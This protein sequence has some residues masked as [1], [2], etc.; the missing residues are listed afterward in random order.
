MFIVHTEKRKLIEI[1]LSGLSKLY[2]NSKAGTLVYLIWLN[3]I[4]HNL[5]Y[6]QEVSTYYTKPSIV[7][8]TT[9]IQESRYTDSVQVSHPYIV[10][11]YYLES[12]PS[13]SSMYLL[14]YLL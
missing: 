12:Y 11:T 8:A 5:E 13:V 2:S 10:F 9:N 7:I 14:T 4:S 3:L 6:V 1:S